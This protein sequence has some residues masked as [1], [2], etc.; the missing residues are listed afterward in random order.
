MIP[1][2]SVWVAEQRGRDGEMLTGDRWVSAKALSTPITGFLG[3]EMVA[4]V[5]V[6]SNKFVMVKRERCRASHKE[7]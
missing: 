5:R 1:V 4:A 6:T 3:Q 2:K 7:E